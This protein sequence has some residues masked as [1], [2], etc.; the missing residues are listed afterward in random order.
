MQFTSTSKFLST[1][2]FA[3][4]VVCITGAQAIPTPLAVGGDEAYGSCQTDC[5]TNTVACY[6]ANNATFG[7]VVAVHGQAM[8]GIL[9]CNKAQG[10]CHAACAAKHLKSPNPPAT[11]RRL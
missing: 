4:A 7:T 10:A 9:A 1:L 3:I 11:R 5:N 2:A 6:K 8:P